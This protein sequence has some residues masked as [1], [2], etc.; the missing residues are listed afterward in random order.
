MDDVNEEAPCNLFE[1]CHLSVAHVRVAHAHISRWRQE[2]AKEKVIQRLSGDSRSHG[3]YSYLYMVAYIVLPRDELPF[4]SNL[5]SSC[6]HERQMFHV[7]TRQLLRNSL[8]D[9]HGLHERSVSTMLHHVI[10][11]PSDLHK[12]AVM[13]MLCS[14]LAEAL[15]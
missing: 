12:E 5:A 2:K 13:I 7:F 9:R 14:Q 4:G 10:S 3:Q 11:H 15:R 8:T 1:I 6:G